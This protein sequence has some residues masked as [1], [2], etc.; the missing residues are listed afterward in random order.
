MGRIVCAR[1]DDPGPE[2][3]LSLAGAICCQI[4]LFLHK[5]TTTL[6][7]PQSTESHNADVALSL[8]NV[9]IS[10]GNFEAVKNVYCEIPRGKV[11]AFIGPSGCGKSTVLRSLN[12]M[13]DLI[14]GCSLKGS[15]LFG[16]RPLRAQ[17]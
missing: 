11:T 5:T 17:D 3:V 13:N 15:I 1:G 12:R 7:Q 10:Y 2:S 8:Q 16:C 9:T 14:E 6:Q 4:N